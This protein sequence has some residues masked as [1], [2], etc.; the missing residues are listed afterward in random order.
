MSIKVY[1]PLKNLGALRTVCSAW[2]WRHGAP[3]RL[4]AELGVFAAFLGISRHKG[5]RRKREKKI[6]QIQSR[7]KRSKAPKLPR[8]ALLVRLRR[9]ARKIVCGVL[10]WSQKGARSSPGRAIH[11][12]DT[13]LLNPCLHPNHPFIRISRWHSK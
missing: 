3:F 7:K 12:S 13:R 8:F 2:F 4:A 5:H 11:N 10:R 9:F 6:Q 1:I